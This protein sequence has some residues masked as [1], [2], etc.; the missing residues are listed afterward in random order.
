[1]AAFSPAMILIQRW[2]R[3]AFCFL[4]RTVPWLSPAPAAII[5]AILWQAMMMIQRLPAV[6]TCTPGIQ[7]QALIMPGRVALAE[8]IKMAAMAAMQVHPA[9]ITAVMADML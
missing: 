8:H 9:A 1:M 4:W 3:A 7:E 2:A 5:P 6:F